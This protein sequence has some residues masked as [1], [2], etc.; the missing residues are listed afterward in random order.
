MINPNRIR[1]IEK[2]E[3]MKVDL[4]FFINDPSVEEV[5]LKDYEWEDDDLGED[6]ELAIDLL[7][8]IER[9]IKSLA[10]MKL[11]EKD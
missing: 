7:E 10:G 9:R 6:R 2:L 11:P 4:V 3:E 5:Y 8:R 1:S